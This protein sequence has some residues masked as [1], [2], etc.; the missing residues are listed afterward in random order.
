[1][2]Q[3]STSGSLVFSITPQNGTDDYDFLLYGPNVTC[4]ALG[5]P[6]RCSDSY[7]GGATG[8]NYT[9]VDVSEN[10]EG[11]K[12]CSA[13]NVLAGQIYYLLVDEWTNTGLGYSIAFTGSTATISCAPL[14]VNFLTFTAK[15]NEDKKGVDLK[16]ATA[17]EENN[18]HF[19][20]EKSVNGMDFQKITAVDGSGN[21]T[22]VHNYSAFDAR[23]YYKEINYYRLKQVDY[24]GNFHYSDVVAVVVE[25]PETYFSISPNP[26]TYESKI[27]YNSS[28]ADAW[29]VSIYSEMG[30]KVF[31]RQVKSEQG[32]NEL[33]VPFKSLGQGVYLIKMKDSNQTY[34]GKFVIY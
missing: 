11:D 3:I 4:G 29:N 18:S 13:L 6:T 1:V 33:D 28:M 24:D 7:L 15:Y 12:W 17:S 9:A 21:S 32:P 19:D 8:L 16:W 20:V 31:E 10:V 30:N 5:N 34:Q 25:H 22:S 2:F 26:I 27:H 14:P 23:P